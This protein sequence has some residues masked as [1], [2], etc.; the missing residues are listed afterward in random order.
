MKKPI[1]L[2]LSAALSLTFFTAC[3]KEES[4]PSTEATTLPTVPSTAQTQ[5]TQPTQVTEPLVEGD[6]LPAPEKTV[7]VGD[8]R[9][10]TMTVKVTATNGT[11]RRVTYALRN[12]AGKL[13]FYERNAEAD[14]TAAQ[15]Y[16][17]ESICLADG[18]DI[19][20]FS[21]RDISGTGF[22]ETELEAEY[23]SADGHFRSALADL[24]FDFGDWIHTDGFAKGEAVQYL[25]RTCDAYD[26]AYTDLFGA[27][28]KA[29]ILVDRQTGIWLRS[30]RTIPGTDDTIVMEVESLEEDSHVIPGSRPVALQEQVVYRE[31]G[32]TITAKALDFSDPNKV[33]LTLET[34]NGTDTDICAT[35]RYVKLNGL[36]ADLQ[37]QI[38]CGVGQTQ[39][40]LVEL[41]NPLLDRSGIGILDRME[42][43]LT[44]EKTHT[45][46]DGTVIS[47]GFLVEDTGAL[48][49]RTECPGDYV[50]T[51]DRQ[52][53]ML[54]G[55][56]EVTLL[57]QSFRVED[58]GDAWFGVY[59]EDLYT[60]P[61]R[62]VMEL[63]SVNGT[64]LP[65]T[66]QF[67]MGAQAEGYDGFVIEQE[68]L[69]AAGIWEI[70]EAELSCA[71]YHGDTRLVESSILTVT[72]E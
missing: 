18:A 72:F 10:L 67:V 54:I 34:V 1:C 60:H 33:V 11:V 57:A 41:P 13:T 23:Q 21:N 35:G 42:L 26:T 27:G 19:R 55:I 70:R 17:Y 38:L 20:M 62:V 32:V 63:K 50:Q 14:P 2:L 7:S 29:Q 44:I 51:V 37:P 3:A 48:H 15:P 61:V 16:G 36:Y 30:Q 6:L 46:A 28:Y 53:Q 71:V 25:D 24:G 58:S 9:D 52:G 66:H 64:P 31:D 45:E 68:A 47:D 4:T 59:C 22:L 40:T 65:M 5:S 12:D 56:E 39:Q 43:A 8:F 49:I 69:A